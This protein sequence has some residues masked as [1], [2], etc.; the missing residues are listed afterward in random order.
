M[1]QQELDYAVALSDKGSALA[2]A[3]VIPVIAVPAGTVIMNAGVEVVVA[4]SAGT[5]TF[6]VGTG[7]DVDCFVDGFDGDSGTAA[8]TY[9]QNAAAFQ[10]IVCLADDNIDVKLITQSGTALTTGKIRVWA[11]LMDVSDLGTLS[12]SE[13][14]RDVLA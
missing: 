14:D 7:V 2:A 4:S 10:P 9:S 6:D 13:V 8:G 5:M 12:A 11:L 1:V 3:D